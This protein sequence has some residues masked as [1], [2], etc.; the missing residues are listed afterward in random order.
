MFQYHK[1]K[2]SGALIGDII[3]FFG[4][5]ILKYLL[6]FK[7]RMTKTCARAFLRTYKDTAVEVTQTF[8]ILIRSLQVIFLKICNNK[9][10]Y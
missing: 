3:T 4:I 8:V 9:S 1:A 7:A 2:R 6:I 10:S 5:N